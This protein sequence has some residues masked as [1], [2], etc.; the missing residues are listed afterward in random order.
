MAMVL[1]KCSTGRRFS[2]ISFNTFAPP[3]QVLSPRTNHAR[4]GT[5]PGY[6]PH[7]LLATADP[8]SP[9]TLSAALFS[10]TVRG[11]GGFD[12]HPEF[13]YPASHHRRD[14]LMTTAPRSHSEPT[15]ATSHDVIGL[16]HRQV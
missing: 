11:V 8:M 4:A 7:F 12:H 16:Y 6:V 14:P 3:P 5:T 9:E 15:P 13:S 2:F 10:P 1:Q